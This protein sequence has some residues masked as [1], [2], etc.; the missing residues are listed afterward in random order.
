MSAEP[1]AKIDDVELAWKTLSAA[2]KTRAGYWLN[3]ASRKIRRR[4]KD[5]D[6][7]IAAAQLDPG[8]VADVVVALV[9]DVLPSLDNAGV[10]SMSVQAGS[11]GRSFTLEDRGNQDRLHLEDWMIEILDGSAS[12]GATPQIA[13]PRPYDFNRVFPDMREI[14]DK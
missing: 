14:Y 7:R 8:D 5:I 1:F 6:A 13:A 4:W 3:A 12:R 10:R 9:I 11:M 2:E